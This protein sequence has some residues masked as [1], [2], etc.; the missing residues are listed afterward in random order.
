MKYRI[1][2]ASHRGPVFYERKTLEEL[3]SLLMAFFQ[4]GCESKTA[5]AWVE[6]RGKWAPVWPWQLED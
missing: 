2:E 4:G 6:K 1:V 5:S 3:A